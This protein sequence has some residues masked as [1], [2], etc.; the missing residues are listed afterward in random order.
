MFDKLRKWQVEPANRL[1]AALRTGQSC[2]D[3][4]DTGTGKTYV[5]AAVAASLGY[6]MVTVVPKIA[7]SN[8][9]AI[10]RYVGG[11]EHVVVG[12]EQLAGGRTGFGTWTNNP[13][14]G[15]RLEQQ[16]VCESCQCV[17]DFDDYR[18][19]YCHGAGIHCVKTKKKPWKYGQFIWNESVRLLVF[20]EIHRCSGLDSNTAELL[21][22][23]RRQNIPVLGL[24]ATAACTPLQ[25]RALGFVLGLHNLGSSWRNFAYRYK[26]R[27]DPRFHGLKWLA[28]REEQKAIMAEIRSDII[29]SRG[30]RV[31]RESI[32][33]FPK[34]QILCGLYDIQQPEQIDAAYQE[35]V[36]ALRQLEVRAESDSE[37][38]ITKI[39]RARQRIE[40]L[41]VPVTV[42]LAADELAKWNW[43][44]IF[45]NF[46]ETIAQLRRKFPDAGVIDGQQSAAARQRAIDDFQSNKSRII[47][48]NGAAGGA[49]IS[50]HDEHGEHPRI[51]LVMPGNNAV[52][53]QQIFGRLPRDGGKSAVVYRV[54]LAAHTIETRMHKAMSAKLDN[55]SALNDA[56]LNPQNLCL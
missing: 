30:V 47:L 25:L 45:V 20:D 3:L 23:A 51:G 49:A 2:V 42:E 33:N 16:Y 12:Y 52:Q 27:H 48:V 8:W 35:L 21:I 9:K 41:K 56:D 6:P 4:S 15:F 28:G 43:V 13:P 22:A 7:V 17:V 46:S 32:P 19:C 39:L 40:L 37:L 44:A 24:S 18:K 1:L 10:H 11:Y 54:I 36:P 53:L 34:C 55:M 5:A 38:A 14:K 31:T 50:L 29:P 26:C